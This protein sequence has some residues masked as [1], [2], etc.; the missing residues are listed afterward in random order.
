MTGYSFQSTLL[1]AYARI[2]LPFRYATP[3]VEVAG[4]AV[5]FQRG[6]DNPA[7]C[8]NR[9]GLGGALSLGIDA[10]VVP[11]VAIGLR[12]GARNPGAGACV[13]NSRAP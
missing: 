2:Q 13:S 1:A 8:Y 4:G 9:S 3:Y 11:S 5:L 6:E 7:K 10:N 12:G